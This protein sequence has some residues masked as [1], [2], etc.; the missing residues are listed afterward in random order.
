M[1]KFTQVR[2]AQITGSAPDL[3]SAFTDGT[4]ANGTAAPDL[5]AADLG[6]I[7][8][9]YGNTLSAISGK[10]D[11]FGLQVGQLKHDLTR[12]QGNQVRLVASGAQAN[13]GLQVGI[14]GHAAPD[15]LNFASQGAALVLGQGNSAGNESVT[16]RN[17]VGS[18][19]VLASNAAIK[20]DAAAGG[21]TALANKDLRLKAAETFHATG[22]AGADIV[23]E[24][25]VARITGLGNAADK[26]VFVSAPQGTITLKSDRPDETGAIV[27]EATATTSKISLQNSTTSLLEVEAGKVV[28]TT[29]A[30]VKFLKVADSDFNAASAALLVSG[31]VRIA[32]N[33]DLVEGDL[34]IRAD[35]KA[36]KF[37]SAGVPKILK[38]AAK[39]KLQIEADDVAGW[40]V[41]IS[42]SAGVAAHGG[43]GGVLLTGA[44][45]PLL[46]GDG[47]FAF[48][49]GTE[50]GLATYGANHELVHYKQT[51]VSSG[52]GTTSIIAALNSL[53][54]RIS[55]TDQSS[56]KLVQPTDA[57]GT[58]SVTVNLEAGS[59][60]NFKTAAKNQ[61]DVFVNGQLLISGASDADGD[62]KVDGTGNNK[63]QF[64]FPLKADDVI[65][66]LDKQ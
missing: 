63:I 42:G 32:K 35:G 1:S 17:S 56:F 16:I 60:A 59:P 36:A 26:G 45:G 57:G 62:Y 40:A 43:Q 50:N 29:D 25:G 22:S 51:F 24:D 15:G 58:P 41:G 30:E 10:A 4:V 7:L 39:N 19:D 54:S 31:G 13:S 65:R 46:G 64:F 61:L 12:A 23:A 48:G 28:G 11:F 49:A 37:G 34:Q 20:L 9:A 27:L 5:D 47:L 55:S 6:D 66:V 38:V 44:F 33:V 52:S 8:K 2:L 14:A 21:L 53:D 3:L 18:Q